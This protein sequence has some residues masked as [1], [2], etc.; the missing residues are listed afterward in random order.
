[1]PDRYQW[2][3]EDRRSLRAELEARYKWHRPNPDDTSRFAKMASRRM[4]RLIQGARFRAVLG[5]AIPAPDHKHIIRAM[6]V[7]DRKQA[8][9]CISS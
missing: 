9:S 4:R 5:H 3:C 6:K 1:M 8:A 2:P 7:L